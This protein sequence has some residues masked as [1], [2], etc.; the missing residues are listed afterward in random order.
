MGAAQSCRDGAPLWVDVGW[1]LTYFDNIQI[2]Y[3]DGRIDDASYARYAAAVA[4]HIDGRNAE[5][6]VGV[7]YHVPQ[8]AALT[9][10]RR[11]LL[12]RVLKERETQLARTTT[13][14]ALAT[15]SMVVRS[16]LRIL[17]WL[18]PPPYRNAVVATPRAAF[19]FVA[20]HHP[21]AS[22]EALEQRYA[23]LL[24]GLMARMSPP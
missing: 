8:P 19:E 22:V 24:A 9:A 23:A 1:F 10:D 4:E 7:V 13:A 21:G 12:G 5:A 14:F 18:A 3:M 17:Y 20:P 11:Q 6:R 16:G 2:V 15:A